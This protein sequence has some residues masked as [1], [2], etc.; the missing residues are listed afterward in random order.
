MADI[1]DLP[2]PRKDSVD[3]S[4]LP[5]PKTD[6]VPTTEKRE[7]DLIDR[8]ARVGRETLTGG[9]YGGFA[10]EMMQAAGGG[11]RRVGQAMGPYGRIPMA[12][13]G[14]LET[15]GTAMK[16]ARP[17]SFAAGTL[18]GAI[19]ETGGQVVE[20]Q[21]GPGLGAESARFLGATLGPAPFQFLGS[22]TGRALGTIAGKLG[23]PGMSTAKT[24]G[25]LLQEAN[26]RPESIT[27]QQ[28]AFIEKKISDVRG[29]QPS[30]DAQKEIMD[31]LKKGAQQ[32][33]QTGEQQAGQLERQAAQVIQD[34][35]AAG[36]RLTSELQNRIN[37][38]QSQF[39]SAAMS[40]RDSGQKQAQKIVSDAQAQADRI[41][42]NAAQQAPS[43]RQ[44]AETEAKAAIDQG[45][46]QADKIMSD[47]TE[48][49]NRLQSTRN[50]LR[51][52]IAPREAAAQQ[53]LA[54]VG[55]PQ[56]PTTL[57]K[58]IRQGFDDVLNRLKT[59]RQENVE[60]YKTEAFN[61]ALVNEASGLR[62]QQTDAY[63][64]AMKAID[65][66]I[67]SPITGLSNVPEGEIR[68]GLDKV[69]EALTSEMSFEGLEKLR[70]SLRDRS[71]G[72][73]AEGFD[74][75]GQQQAGK[76]AVKVEDIMEEFSPGFRKYLQQYAE[77]SKPLN[78]FKNDLGRAI[79]G[80]E[81]FD[82]SMFSTDPARLADMVFSSGSTVTQ[83]IQTIGRQ[84]AEQIAR[85]YVADKLRNAGSKEIKDFLGD[86][87]TRDW[88]FAFPRIKEQL[89]NV[90]QQMASTEK[91]SGKRTKLSDL[92]RT[93]M[94]AL[95][96]KAQT[97]MTRAEQDA[98]AAAK[99]RLGKAEK[100]AT[101][102]TKAAETAAGRVETQA[103]TEARAARE[104]AE[105]QIGA[106]SKA[107]ERQKGRLETDV[108]RRVAQQEAAAK[109]QAGELTKEAGDVRSKAQELARLITAG[110][111]TGPARVRDLILS[112]NE[113]ELT[114][115]AKI[116]LA[117]PGG[118]EKF[119]EAVGQVIAEKAN[120]NLKGAI[121]DW[122]YIGDNLVSAGLMSAD[123]VARIQSKLQ[124][125][126]V[127]PIDIGEKI[128]WAQRLMR[129]AIA[130]YAAPAVTRAIEPGGQ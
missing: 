121:D 7:P 86:S 111:T 45:R 96:I 60:K 2:P 85:N 23:V 79:T 57:G 71:A 92:L 114:E 95:P 34:A 89:T 21:Y 90:A 105:R 19:G 74:A 126:F 46:A 50:K 101:G 38:L 16:A 33:V 106:S 130:G 116:I 129:N 62:Y 115:A 26:V 128:T 9:I 84:E 65:D 67:A 47:T 4:D 77:D 29:G 70:R 54:E 83:L 69:R 8:A 41:R 99:S 1:S 14:A 119:G 39:E 5:A 53:G 58:R 102:I 82:F 20:S 117:S 103:E 118:K 64:K 3:I 120:K 22:T 11:I 15:G 127:A 49:I 40:I 97:S 109:T 24:I 100:E 78:K 94:G 124:E 18:G 42:Q 125:V 61:N 55:E 108:E 56:L 35:Q 72:L 63:A 43:V 87:K 73:P 51:E 59:K 68:R 30:L 88:L 80:K 28:R 75:I 123:D 110:D 13:G 112:K 93:E 122:R 44:I 107:V 48:R 6:K 12:V 98:A 37:N 25:Q 91:V 10:P 104:A 36:G 17:A 31:M 81:D 52:S 76:L 66:E 113:K 27:P 32:I